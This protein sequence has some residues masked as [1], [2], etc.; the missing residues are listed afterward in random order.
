MSPS[1]PGAETVHELIAGESAGRVDRALAERLPFSRSRIHRLIEEG[2]VSVDGV[3]VKKASEPLA[4]GAR[5]RVVVPPKPEP[6]FGGEAIAVP[7]LHE[8]DD[9]LVVDKPAG[10]VVHPAPGHPSGTLVNALIH[11]RPEVAGVGSERKAGIVHRLDRD[12]SGC[13]VVAKHDRAHAALSR[14]FAERTVE[15]R[16]WAWVWGHLREEEGEIDRPIGRSRHDR[17]R[18]SSRTRSGRGAVTRWRVVER[19][20]VADWVEVSPETGRTHQI[21]VHLA[22]AGHP[23]V[24]DSRYGGGPTRARGFHG[25]QQ[26]LAE[27]VADLAGRQALHAR[28]LAFDQPTTGRRV[29]VE[30]P[31]PDDLRRLLETLREAR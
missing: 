4:E 31:L 20:P 11:L 16:Y 22:E 25:P 14:Q 12:T 18:M 17:Q 19:Y 27:R 29:E 26:R 10:L 6:S 30:S 7:I 3:P 2:R 5:I 24:G 8:D 23:V 28:A 13:L 1:P 9:S 21:R 15:K